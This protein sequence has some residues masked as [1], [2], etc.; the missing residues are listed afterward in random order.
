M[1][2]ADNTTGSITC[3][4]QMMRKGDASALRGLWQRFLPRLLG[5]ARKALSGRPQVAADAEDAVQS[6]FASFWQRVEQGE[7]PGTMDRDDLWNLL[8]VITV[9][10]ARK[11]I[12]RETAQKRGGGHVIS[13]AGLVNPDGS[14]RRLEEIA[15]EVP[16]HDLDLS[17]EELLLSLDEELRDY[18]V[19]RLMGY[20]N[21]EIADRF[22]C[23]ER[24]VER[25]LN[26][27]RL[28]WERLYPVE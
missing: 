25:K 28:Q 17:C 21:A 7:F 18:A 3:L 22:G 27:I 12:R 4:F 15:G 9:R 23:T 16:A 1:D 10:K 11:Q 20:R 2:G 8:G 5:L 6:A 26:L 24:K 14:P 19:L 13:E